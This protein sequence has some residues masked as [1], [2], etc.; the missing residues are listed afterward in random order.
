MP[1][2]VFD[3]MLVAAWD[4]AAPVMHLGNELAPIYRFDD[5]ID[6]YRFSLALHAAGED[7]F[8]AVE[9]RIEALTEARIFRHTTLEGKPPLPPAL[10]E[11]VLRWAKMGISW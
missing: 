3:R 8:G 1:S 4:E 7:F 5:R 6:L 2:Q 10:K 11:L 9:R